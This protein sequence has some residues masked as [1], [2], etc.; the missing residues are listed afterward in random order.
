LFVGEAGVGRVIA[1]TCELMKQHDTDRIGEFGGI[2]LAIIQ[3]YLNFHYSVSL[4][5]FGSELSTNA[6]NYFSA[7]LKGR[8]READATDDHRLTESVRR[9]LKPQ[10]G[11]IVE[12]EQPA[13]AA[14][15]E[16]LRDSYVADCERALARWNKI[17]RDTEVDCA[18][19]LPHRGFNRAIGH[20]SGS[21]VTPTGEVIT[22]EDW[23]ERHAEWLPTRT[24]REFVASLM[25]PVTELGRFAG[26]IAPPVRGI[27]H[28]PIEFDYV[29]G[30][31]TA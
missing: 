1:R 8:F 6:A 28:Q 7:G 10:D 11:A 27:N 21:S 23:L 16:T 13:L 14:L 2:D 15:N 3:R 18:L 25:Q 19:T 22:R 17:I 26:W 30:L 9:I 5:L 31:P 24:D 29:T 4:D 12:I 20:F